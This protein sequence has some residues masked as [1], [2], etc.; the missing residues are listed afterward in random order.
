MQNWIKK[1]QYLSAFLLSFLLGLIITVPWIIQGNGIFTFLADYNAQQIPFNIYM[2]DAFANNNYLWNWYNDLGASFIGSFGL[3]NL[4]SPFTMILWIFPAKFVPYL[5]G[6]MFIIKYGVAGLTSYLFLKRYVKN[7]K[8][9][10]LGSLLYTFSGFQLTNIVFYHF[11]DVVALFPLLLYSLDRLVIEKKKGLFLLSVALNAIT[12]YY[13]FVGQVVFVI[14][15]YVIKIITKE[16]EWSFK[17][18][19]TIFIESVLGLGIAAFLFVPSVLF[20]L[21][22]PRVESGWTLYSMFRPIGINIT[23]IIRAL[24]MPNESMNFRAMLSGNNFCSIEA[25]LPF[26][27]AILWLSYLIKKPKDWSNVLMFVILIF[28]VVPI[29]NSSFSMFTTTYYA[30]WFYMA[31]IIM[32]LNSIKALDENISIKYGVIINLIL[33]VIFFA[34]AFYV[35]RNRDLINNFEHF[36]VIMIFTFLNIILMAIIFKYNKRRDLWLFIFVVLYIILYGNY[37]IYNNKKLVNYQEPMTTL[38]SLENVV[39]DL[40]DNVRYNTDD[41]YY[42]AG[43]YTK[44]MFV[45]SWNSNIEGSAFSFYNSLGIYRGVLTVITLVDD[46]LQDFLSVKYI[47]LNYSHDDLIERYGN[48]IE[49][50]GFYI[51]V[52][53]DYKPMGIDYDHYILDTDFATK[54]D[55]DKTKILNNAIVITE[56][57]LDKYKNILIEYDEDVNYESDLINN[58]FCLTNFGFTSDLTSSNEKLLVYTVPYSSGWSATVNGENAEIELVDNGLMAIK[59]DEGDNKI[60]FRYCPPGLKIGIIITGCSL[61]GALLYLEINGRKRMK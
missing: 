59:I 45:T 34:L 5:M 42:N 13:F 19:M 8:Y 1:H 25:Y 28:M 17:S 39:A 7:F 27:G 41:Y 49:K 29:L 56:E 46:N 20:V 12:N 38:N 52:N 24:I 9:A 21:G 23:E 6:P 57:Q 32:V 11:H 14:V 55:Q 16:Y 22:N 3:Y 36:I 2:S 51:Y 44:R 33:I 15:Y 61:L 4:F 31:V 48:P 26:V 18:F 10:L 40:E 37:F 50:D 30:R 60:E 58:D 47:I 54:T 43:L 35:C 53:D